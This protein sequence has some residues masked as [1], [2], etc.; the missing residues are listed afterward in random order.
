MREMLRTMSADFGPATV[1]EISDETER[2]T[3]SVASMLRRAMSAGWVE[4]GM[5][6]GVYE[7]VVT[8]A[9][10]EVTR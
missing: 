2:P 1:R 10:R 8:P 7:Y 3:S 6:A 9:G 5:V 4:R